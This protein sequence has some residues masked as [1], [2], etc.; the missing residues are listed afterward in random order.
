MAG[1]PKKKV[2]T[3]DVSAAI[4]APETGEMGNGTLEDIKAILEEIKD[5]LDAQWRGRNPY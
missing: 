4:I 3:T 1:K 5:I 2:A